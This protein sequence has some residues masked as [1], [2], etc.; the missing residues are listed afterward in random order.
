[1]K[2]FFDKKIIDKKFYFKSK[3]AFLFLLFN[4]ILEII[5]LGTIPIILN[6]FL[7]PESI[8]INYPIF[9]S[10]YPSSMAKDDIIVYGLFLVVIFFLIKNLFLIYFNYFER[11]FLIK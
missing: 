5:S 6:F 10:I 4:S 1:M 7:K 2:F 8:L 3:L 9:N 11:S